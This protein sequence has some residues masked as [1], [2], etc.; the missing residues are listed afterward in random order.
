[1]PYFNRND[2]TYTPLF[3]EENIWKLIESLYTNKLA[4]PIDVLFILNENNTISLF[5]QKRSSKGRPVIWDYHVILVAKKEN[6]VLIFDFDSRCDF[7]ES[8][9]DYFSLTFPGNLTIEESYRPLINAISADEYF[10]LFHSDRHH[11]KGIIDDCDF[12]DYEIIKPENIKEALTLDQCRKTLSG[13][14]KPI[15]PS[16]YLSDKKSI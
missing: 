16:D 4:I 5:E 15:S 1:M 11:M 14:K 10:K 8:I 7:P 2:F 12:P 13:D 6:E 3:C 9:N